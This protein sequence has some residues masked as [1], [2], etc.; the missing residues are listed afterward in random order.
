MAVK[1]IKE[2]PGRQ[3]DGKMDRLK[4]DILEIIEKR[5]PMAEIVDSPYTEQTMRARMTT[6]I[7]KIV[8]EYSEKKGTKHIPFVKKVIDFKVR[9]VDGEFHYY[10]IFNPELWDEEWKKIFLAEGI[11]DD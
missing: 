1:P 3:V 11:E 2:I 4:A 6:A 10:V 8:W 7:R 5:I 9:K